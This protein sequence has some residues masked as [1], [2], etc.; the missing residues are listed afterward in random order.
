MDERPD[1]EYDSEFSEMN[2][3]MRQLEYQ[4]HDSKHNKTKND[5][6][7]LRDELNSV[8]EDYKNKNKKD[9]FEA[10]DFTDL[11]DYNEKK[12]KKDISVFGQ[13]EVSSTRIRCPRLERFSR[14][15]VIKCKDF[16]GELGSI[17]VCQVFCRVSGSRQSSYTSY[18]VCGKETKY[19]W[20]YELRGYKTPQ[21]DCIRDAIK[22][23]RFH[24]KT[25]C[26]TKECFE[27]AAYYTNKIDFTINPCDDFYKYACGRW[28]KESKIPK[29][30]MSISTYSVI[31]DRVKLELAGLM[32][33]RET[34][35]DISAIVKAKE[36][37]KSC[38]NT[39]LIE[40]RGSGPLLNLL[41]G[42]LSWPIL[43][44]D[45]CCHGRLLSDTIATLRR[46]NND[47]L[48][49][50]EVIEE[51]E[52]YIMGIYKGGMAMNNAV[53]TS[54]RYTE[55]RKAYF[56]MIAETALKLNADGDTV[57]RDIEDLARFEIELVGLLEEDY[58]E[59]EEHYELKDLDRE[60]RNSKINFGRLF[61][62]MIL[63][64]KVTDNLKVKVKNVK[65]LKKLL[66]LVDRTPTRTILNYIIWR[67]VKH[68]LSSLG[69]PFRSEL[70]KFRTSYGIK[71][72]TPR[73]KTCSKQIIKGL[74]VVTGHLFITKYFDP[75]KRESAEILFKNVRKGFI[76]NLEH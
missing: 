62:K 55:V 13:H 73:W 25:Q 60:F 21:Q 56:K 49:R 26:T 50:F 29:H 43:G 45:A 14:N 30:R 15:Q 65:W 6:F 68:R 52:H 63:E 31:R 36:I 47:N 32:N 27:T 16:D 20:S 11:K 67:F 4:N 51:D 59:K 71:S 40:I 72:Q 75:K 57:V 54:D 23:E 41:R 10:H 1:S 33:S 66:I 74:P 46:Y 35:K 44:T 12:S 37:F 3:V 69:S 58:L 64:Q 22:F 9:N 70:L 61:R 7:N 28:L 19:R 5:D 34:K 18:E 2:V 8:V 39:K 24:D 76:Y 48:M 42:D 53:Y 38:M 17:T